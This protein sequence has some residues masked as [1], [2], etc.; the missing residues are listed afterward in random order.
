M[1]DTPKSRQKA[2]FEVL[3]SIYGDQI[4]DQKS[5]AKSKDFKPLNF[6]IR[7]FPQ[8]GSFDGLKEH[9]AFVDLNIKCSQ[10]YPDGILEFN[11]DKGKGLSN[12][13]LEQLQ[14]E[15]IQKCQDLLGNEAIFELCQHVEEYLHKH[16]KPPEKSFYD[17]MIKRQEIEKIKNQEAKQLEDYQNQR[18]LQ[19]EINKILS[20]QENFRRKSNSGSLNENVSRN[21]YLSNDRKEQASSESSDGIFCS[22]ELS[23][24]LIFTKHKKQEILKGTCLDHPSQSCTVF[25]GFDKETGEHLVITEWVINLKND[26]TLIN[27]EFSN[28]EQEFTTNIVKLKHQNLVEYKN[29]MFI[30]KEDNATVYVLSEFVVGINCDT[31][32]QIDVTI[33]IS[34]LKL[35]SKGILQALDYLHKKNIVHRNIK[36]SCIFIN[37]KGVVKVSNYN[38]H[39]KISDLVYLSSCLNND[40]K[41]TDIYNFGKIILSLLKGSPIYDDNLDISDS[42]PSDLND[43]LRRCLAKEDRDRSS[44]YQLL[45]HQ[46]FHIKPTVHFE[47]DNK[48]KDII[49]DDDI[50][51]NEISVDDLNLSHSQSRIANEF[52]FIEF[53][54]QGAFG[55]VRK[56]RNK[57]DNR[58][59]AIK[60]IKLNPKNKQLNK[61]IV[62]E[63]QLLSRLNHENVVR[64]YNSWIETQ[65]KNENFESD[66]EIS[67]ENPNKVPVIIKRDEF[68]FNDKIEE[69]APVIK[70]SVTYDSKSQM[71]FNNSLDDDSS[72]SSDD[73][74]INAWNPR[75]NKESESDGIEFE[76]EVSSKTKDESYKHGSRYFDDKPSFDN[77]I[78]IDYMYIQMEFC[79]KSTLRIAIDDNLY[80]DEE[81]VKRLFREIVEGLAHIHQQGMIHRDLKPVNIFLDLQDHVKIGDFGLATTNLKSKMND[82]SLTKSA[83]ETFKEEGIDDESKTGNIGTT[84]YV[85]PELNSGS[86]VIYNEKVD[87]YSL[88]VILFEMSYKALNT[89][90][91]RIKVL[92]GIRKKEIK[93]PDDLSDSLVEKHS[94]LIR[95]LLDH[96]VSKRPTSQELLQSEHMPPPVVEET[97]LMDLI[98]HTLHHP[99]LKGY[100]Y[101]IASCFHQKLTAAQDITYDRDT[102]NAIL[103][104]PLNIYEQIREVTVMVFKKHGGQNIATPLLMPSSKFY[105]NLEYCVKLMT[106]GGGIVTLPY[107]L[108]V[109]FARYVAWNNIAL[110]RRYSIERVYREKKFFGFLPRELY[111]CAFDIVT[112]TPGTL[113]SDAEIL[114]IM[115]EIVNEISALKSKN[116]VIHLNHAQLLCSILLYYGIKKDL[117]QE[118]ILMFT[119]V[120]QEKLEKTKLHAY[121]MSLGLSETNVANLLSLLNSEIEVDNITTNFLMITKKKSTEASQMAKQ[122]LNDLKTVIQNTRSMGLNLEIVLTPGLVYNMH[123]YSGTLFQFVCE[124]RKKRQ[125]NKMEVIAAGGRYDSMIASYRSMVRGNTFSRDISQSAVGISISLDKI[126]Q[127]VQKS[128]ALLERKN[129]FE[130]ILAST[131]ARQYLKEKVRIL[132]CLWSLGINYTL[133]E[134]SN[135]KEIEEIREELKVPNVI[136]FKD[137]DPDTVILRSLEKD[138]F[139]EKSLTISELIEELQRLLK[140]TNNSFQENLNTKQDVNLARLDNKI[141]RSHSNEPWVSIIFAK[142][143]KLP[144]NLRKRHEN[145]ISSHLNEILQRLS[146]DVVVFALNVEGLVIKSLAAY[147]DF[148]SEESFQRSLS[149]VMEKH[150]KYKNTRDFCDD[151]FKQK[152]KFNKPIVILYSLINNIYKMI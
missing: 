74:G 139:Q 90:M 51:K 117:Q 123:Q 111:E 35:I 10:H 86:R 2:E 110:F 84:L 4:Y 11:I 133:L 66:S 52:E 85:A 151:I 60:R 49:P 47:L 137:A 79:E 140:R 8:K 88:G 143:E 69:L 56:F 95:W 147:L 105:G 120:K 70:V 129:G 20:Q 59:Y 96:D 5:K 34:I 23:E 72:D 32:L 109:P 33:D 12:A 94:L 87:I 37:N 128:E 150:P 149:A 122:A 152:N 41:K 98:R 38:I 48:I 26:T 142:T 102:N 112:P 108:R 107:D 121:M 136:M 127:A 19:E 17:E 89:T 82:Y 46:F 125:Q 62:R 54:G 78:K 146:G 3:K 83:V 6:I 61:K 130:I 24:T 80:K 93:F 53:I 141:E 1:E 118:F 103:N 132:S 7:L 29:L 18:D 40:N 134:T 148:D 63:V 100:K 21:N 116:V 131:G 55:D 28:I 67:S 44:A 43:F 115:F 27:R 22:H 31:L 97:E 99:E 65:E 14:K 76:N 126:V 9:E 71:G 135:Y 81:R 92:T 42:I 13:L 138:R 36:P 75:Y 77:I 73:E 50:S 113:M 25:I 114:Y 57:L 124:F 39:R 91:E 104:R 145:Q 64:Y 144:T 45:Q 106:H 101:L 68:S 30:F 58:Y 119:D 15:L 16:Y